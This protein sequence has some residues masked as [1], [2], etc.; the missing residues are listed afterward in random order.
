MDRPFH[1]LRHPMPP[2]S[3]CAYCLLTRT[4]PFCCS[5][6]ASHEDGQYPDSHNQSTRWT[7]RRRFHAR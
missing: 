7:G 4:Y 5:V 3:S 6:L 1:S 2:S